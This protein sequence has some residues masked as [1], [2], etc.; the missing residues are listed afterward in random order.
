MKMISRFA[1][2]LCGFLFCSVS[3]GAWAQ[4]EGYPNRPDRKSTRLNS[5]HT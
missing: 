2:L 5:S 3:L 1:G 4:A